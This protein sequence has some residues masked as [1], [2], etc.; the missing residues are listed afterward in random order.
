MKPNPVIYVLCFLFFFYSTLSG[1]PEDSSVPPGKYG[2]ESGDSRSVIRSETLAVSLDN[3]SG[4]LLA[5]RDIEAGFNFIGE[6]LDLFRLKLSKPSEGEEI[7]LTAS[8]FGDVKVSTREGIPGVE[9][10][11]TFEGAERADLR[12]KCS[13]RTG[14]DDPYIKARIEILNHSEWA[15]SLVD[16]PVLKMKTMIGEDASDDVL[17]M[18]TGPGTIVKDPGHKELDIYTNYPGHISFQMMAYFDDHAGLYVALDDSEGNVKFYGVETG[19]GWLDITTGHVNEEIP[20]G[21]YL[22]SY[23]I[24]NAIF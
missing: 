8:D 9:L 7:I 13:F 18:P 1:Q 20:G 12:A 19:D 24:I 17:F 3:E 22:K 15:I 4:K 2:V 6:P 10:I 21:D 11:S 23:S 14:P 16:F 5:I